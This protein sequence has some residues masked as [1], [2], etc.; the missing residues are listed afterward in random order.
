MFSPKATM[1]VI[2]DVALFIIA[3]FSSAQDTK[4][5][6][7][8]AMYYRYLEF[9]SSFK[10]GTITPHWMADGN[11]FWY[12]EGA[13]T[14]TVIWKVDPKTNT[15]TRLFDNV[16]LRKALTQ[17]LVTEPPYQGLP[18]EEFTFVDKGETAI[19]FTVEKKEFILQLDSYAISQAPA[20]STNE[21]SLLLP[22][23]LSKGGYGKRFDVME[24]PSP[25]RNWVVTI[26]DYNLWLRS[27]EDRSLQ[28]TTDGVEDHEWILSGWPG[29]RPQWSHDGARLAMMK[30]DSRRVVK[31]PIIHWLKPN[32]EVEWLPFVN[33]QSGDP[34]PLSELFIF[35][36]NSKQAIRIDTRHEPDQYI[37]IVGWRPDGSELLFFRMNRDLKKLD[38][39]AANPANGVTRVILT[40]TEKTVR[41]YQFFD[42]FMKLF[43]LLKDGKKGIWMSERS[44]WN[45]LY[46]YDINGNLLRQLTNGAFPVVQVITVDE[47]DGW[48]Y[49]T[50][51]DDQLRPYD[52]HLYRVNLDGTGFTRLTE[53]KG[54]HD[55]KF[56]P[57]RKFYL[58]I[59]SNVDRAPVTEMRRADGTLLQTVSRAD[60][61]RLKNELKWSPPEE[62]IVKAADGK[63]NLYGVLYK[64]WDFHPNKKYP[65]IEIIYA[66]DQFSEVQHGFTHRHFGMFE[67]HGEHAQALAQLGFIVFMVDGR[68]TPERGKAFQD[69]GYDKYGSPHVIPDHLGTLK[70]LAKQHPYIDMNRVGIFGHSAGDYFT[71]LAMLQE[72]DIYKVGVGVAGLDI[73]YFIKDTT[74]EGYQSESTIKLAGNLKG[75]LL[76]ING[77]NDIYSPFSQTM[78]MIDAL[79]QAG[80]L[81][82]LIVLPEQGHFFTGTGRTYALEAIRRYFQ[83][84]LKP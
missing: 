34:L 14:N 37:L 72:P 53:V 3:P 52:T 73:S 47:E 79:I 81:Y 51:H 44:G 65:V 33:I 39:M 77:T 43:Q 7:R 9:A 32:V 46:L 42:E 80:K 30:L 50:A 64:P 31:S 69:V 21:K 12:A 38:L 54:Q 35:D 36:I 20:L 76:L 70:Q 18:F 27:T 11:S 28:I 23:L 13:P 10:G 60:I 49:F 67:F 56:S 17:V 68:G 26:K 48:V 16:R 61:S 55:I 83:E 45:H 74:V 8:E 4:Q 84:H 22:Q 41:A 2:L 24:I 15:K 63:T 57:S 19:K 5:A 75:K 62:F 59:H 29:A 58:D 78:K 6:E 82:D 40:E 71:R 25:D 66:G 1:F